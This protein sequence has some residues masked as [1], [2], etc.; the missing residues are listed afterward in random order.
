[1]EVTER[2]FSAALRFLLV[3]TNEVRKSFC[4]NRIGSRAFGR[5][6][7]LVLVA[8]IALGLG[9]IVVEFEKARRTSTSIC[10]NCNLKQ[11]GMGFRTWELDNN[12]QF[13]M[14]ISTNAH[15]SWEYLATSEIFRHF[16]VMSAELST[17]KILVCPNDSR[18]FAGSFER[19]FG[20]SNLGYFVG[21]LSNSTLPQMFLSGDR[22]LKGGRILSNQTAEFATSDRIQWQPL[23]HR[24]YGNI[25]L[26][27]GS[28]Q[29]FNPEAL[30]GALLHS[31]DTNRLAIP[32]M[33]LPQI[34][35]V[36][37]FVTVFI[38][39]AGKAQ[40]FPQLLE[41]AD[42]VDDSASAHSLWRGPF[43]LSL[44]SDNQ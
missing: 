14:V 41:F 25:A 4:S 12:D 29:G 43:P 36:A 33:P 20:N 34:C 16:Q 6:D 27:D 3:Y 24:T 7:L 32:W 31:G 10:C 44:Q 13:P 1:M 8:V 38:V 18:R 35:E 11:I 28:V 9:V 40:M 15:G 42:D 23:L 39:R 30:Q 26:A 21:I 2:G 19:N 5:K 37:D 17:P 22:C